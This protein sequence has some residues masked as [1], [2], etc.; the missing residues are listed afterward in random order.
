MVPV[1]GLFVC[2]FF[3]KHHYS[4]QLKLNCLSQSGIRKPAAMDSQSFQTEA[5][6]RI[7]L[8]I[9]KNVNF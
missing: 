2:L 9:S 4:H 7:F 6:V 1:G 8:N 3:M 5:V